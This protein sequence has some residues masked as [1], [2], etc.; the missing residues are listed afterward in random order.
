[1]GD[2]EVRCGV[3][4][5]GVDADRFA[6][7]A[8][9]PAVVARAEAIRREAGGRRILLGI[10]RLDYTKGIPRRLH[11]VERLLGLAPDLRDGVR[12]IQVAVP[13]RGEVD[14]YQRFKRQVE[15]SV[16]RING[17]CGTVGSTPVHYMHQ[18]VDER[19]L[20]ALYRAADVMV[21]TPLRDGMNLVAK[22]FVAT[23][24]DLDGVLVLS[25][26]AGA[27]AELD[28]AVTVNPYDVQEVAQVLRRALDMPRKERTARMR[29]MRRRVT[30]HDVHH[31]ADTFLARLAA[32]RPP[33]AIRVPRP[34]PALETL[35][36]DAGDR[37]IQ[38]LLNYDGTLVPMARAPHLAAPDDE[39]ITLL[40]ALAATPSVRL[41]I[42]S[43]RDRETLERWLGALDVP[44][45][46][47]H[48]LW[49]RPA[50]GG[51]WQAAATIG[52]DWLDRLEA[53]F[54]EFAAMT[55]GAHV[56]RKTAS[57]AWHYRGAQRHFGARQAH[58]LRMLLGDTLSNQP[59]EVLE[60]SKVIEVRV[61]GVS[62]ALA[63]QRICAEAGDGLIVAMGDDTTDGELFR[64]LPPSSVTVAV[65]GHPRGARYT[66]ADHREVRRLLRLLLATVT[67]DPP[68]GGLRRAPAGSAG[69]GTTAA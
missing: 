48:G 51:A 27:A 67:A 12:F 13:S 61:R 66:V 60:G 47:E 36:Q 14:S 5:M 43:G 30:S 34:E 18:S 4:A 15:E 62:K 35:L 6:A 65:G 39:L 69:A 64:A 22:E 20:A 16:G 52:T 8:A 59:L 40:A 54:A 10:D 46:A 19:E 11:A 68:P 32:A 55:P 33:A 23:R 7:L 58:E 56:E 24:T 42:V 31:W 3:F 25:E 17:A 53:I 1:V 9:E 2:R 50:G 26:F 21:V 38:L 49:F 29:T 41:E 45:S 28:G 37:R 57:I 44:L 63:A